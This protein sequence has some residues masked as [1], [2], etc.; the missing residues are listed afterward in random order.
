MLLMQK[1]FINFI[2]VLN[3]NS[4]KTTEKCHR[5]SERDSHLIIAMMMSDFP[6]KSRSQDEGSNSRN[7]REEHESPS[8]KPGSAG[9]HRKRSEERRVGK[10]CRSR[11]VPSH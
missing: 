10:E 4:M 3:V 5:V 11:W 9:T 8:R 6:N 1:L 7:D 2:Y